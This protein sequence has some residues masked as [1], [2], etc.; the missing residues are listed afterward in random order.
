MIGV[1]IAENVIGSPSFASF[2]EKG[3]EARGRSMQ[4]RRIVSIAFA[5]AALGAG[6][7]VVQAA[8]GFATA[9]V[10]LRSGPDTEYP[11]VGVIPEGEPV[12][13][14]GCLKDESWCDVHWGSEQGWVFS[15]YLALNHRGEMT[16]LP[17]IG[18]STYRIPVVVFRAG[19]YW[20]RHY[21][22]RPWYKDRDRWV[23][24]K[25]RPRA[26]W[27]APPPGARKPGWWRSGYHTPKGMKPPPDR[28]WRRHDHDRRHD[29][30]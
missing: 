30:H 27:H 8:P 24:Y 12:D 2:L 28:G 16:P 25:P 29:R 20:K 15:E 5:V 14:R 10:N 23:A 17:D 21:V 6:A 9:N 3:A 26:G 4:F 22:G 19:D 7:D 13:V 18:L 1:M 11:S